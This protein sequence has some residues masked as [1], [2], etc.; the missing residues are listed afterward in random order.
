MSEILAHQL[1]G[2]R[3]PQRAEGSSREALH[4]NSDLRLC[5]PGGEYHGNTYYQ[6]DLTQLVAC[7]DQGGFADDESGVWRFE[8]Q[9]ARFV[10]DP[11]FGRWDTLTTTHSIDAT[12]PGSLEEGAWLRARDPTSEL[13]GPVS[14]AGELVLSAGY[15]R[16]LLGGYQPLAHSNRLR[17]GIRVVNRAGLRSCAPFACT[18]PPCSCAAELSFAAAP[19][20]AELGMEVH[21]DIVPPVCVH[22]AAWLCD[23]V[24]PAVSDAVMG[25]GLGVWSRSSNASA[26][27]MTP[28]PGTTLERCHDLALD[29]PM[30]VVGRAGGGFTSSADT[31]RVQWEGFVDTDSG[32]GRC[33]LDVV[34]VSYPS[35]PELVPV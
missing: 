20:A 17:L 2:S 6:S 27:A 3:L 31:L 15:L 21:V 9:L 14:R 19:W 10:G 5:T 33:E 11:I 24:Q 29:S 23:P 7:W 34:K 8:W 13:L 12:V 1:R 4:G 26:L 32:L 28:E 25:A 30:G 35:S 16:G 18:N 22:A